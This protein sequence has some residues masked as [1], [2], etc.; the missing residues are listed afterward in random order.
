[1]AHPALISFALYA[2]PTLPQELQQLG[3]A[4]GA[5]GYARLHNDHGKGVGA[6][7]LRTIQKMILQRELVKWSVCDGVVRLLNTG[8]HVQGLPLLN[9][10]LIEEHEYYIADLEPMLTRIRRRQGIDIHHARAA[11]ASHCNK[12][13]GLIRAL[14]K[15]FALPMIGARL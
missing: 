8:R 14:E 2:V 4:P 9:G 13:V 1:M 15:N 10:P 3:Y 12:P 7:T 6:P 5:P 11:I